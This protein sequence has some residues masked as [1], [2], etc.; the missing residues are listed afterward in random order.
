MLSSCLDVWIPGYLDVCIFRCL[1]VWIPGCLDTWMSGCL[2]ISMPGCLDTWMSGYLDVWIPGCLDTWMSGCLYI[3]MPGCLAVPPP[4]PCPLTHLPNKDWGSRPSDW[5]PSGKSAAARGYNFTH[6]NIKPSP[7]TF[8][9][10][11]QT[12]SK[13]L[14]ELET[15][16]DSPVGSRLC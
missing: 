15:R 3:L 10:H 2:Y 6:P 16:R 1:A 4:V 8:A 12:L 9:F 7:V 11:R 14:R 13:S 5:G